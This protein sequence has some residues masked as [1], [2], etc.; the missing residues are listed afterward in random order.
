MNENIW[1][2]SCFSHNLNLSEMKTPK[3]YSI[4]GILLFLNVE[5][6][7]TQDLSS[8]CLN[9]YVI[10]T[11]EPV[12]VNFMSLNKSVGSTEMYCFPKEVAFNEIT[13]YWMMAQ[14][15]E[16]EFNLA[17]SDF[18]D[19]LDFVLYK[20]DPSNLQCDKWSTVRCMA[21]GPNLI[22]ENLWMPCAG[23]TGLS[24]SSENIEAFYGCQIPTTNFLSSVK[25]ITGEIYALKV[26]NFTS[27]S[28]FNLTFK[29]KPLFQPTE[30]FPIKTIALSELD[31]EII[32]TNDC[33]KRLGTEST[34]LEEVSKLPGFVIFPNPSSEV[35]NIR[36]HEILTDFYR[37]I[38]HTGMVSGFNK[39]VGSSEFSIPIGFLPS[40]IYLLEL[41][42]TKGE[43]YSKQ[44]IKL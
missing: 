36:A 14:P 22:E 10:C 17:P 28:G 4:L 27:F 9:G 24:S 5:I 31:Q 23:L 15:A 20:L 7:F 6:A 2:N 44:F 41:T 39:V 16:L 19:D 11:D 35:I 3:I 42:D 40:G 30:L 13:I 43:S 32:N 12:N 37:I 34:S 1:N 33:I 29:N 25:A 26:M 18:K 8:N 38:D 21:K